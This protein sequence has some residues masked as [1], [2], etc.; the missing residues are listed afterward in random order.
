MPHGEEIVFEP[1]EEMGGEFVGHSFIEVKK[2]SLYGLPH[3]TEGQKL[4]PGIPRE[5][6]H[7][8]DGWD[9]LAS[10]RDTPRARRYEW[11]MVELRKDG[12][13]FGSPKT[14]HLRPRVETIELAQSSRAAYTRTPFNPRPRN[15]PRGTPRGGSSAGGNLLRELIVEQKQQYQVGLEREREHNRE[16]RDQERRHQEE[17][18]Q[19]ER[20]LNEVRLQRLEEKISEG[21][22]RKDEEPSPFDFK[23]V[24]GQAAVKAIER[25]EEG[26][27]N[28]LLGTLKESEESTGGFWGFLSEVTR[29]VIEAVREDPAGALQL[30][31]T[32]LPGLGAAVARPTPQPEATREQ[33]QPEPAAPITRQQLTDVQLL[34]G[35]TTAL[36]NGIVSDADPAPY[37]QEIRDILEERPH[38]CGSL[39]GMLQ[40]T[41]GELLSTLSATA[42]VSFDALGRKP[43]K[44]TRDLRVALQ[45]YGIGAEMPA[46]VNVST[47]GN[48]A[49]AGAGHG[50]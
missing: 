48:G 12:K 20:Q 46:P 38:L 34:T 49:A 5:F 13:V 23:S 27:A 29:D 7:T 36:A 2:H 30:A 1:D 10:I 15:P 8:V 35:L 18:H 33:K 41:D 16:L 6:I 42:R 44:W 26:I 22:S 50:D 28:N 14:V 32:V 3:Y 43:L 11:L 19:L 31:S 39:E 4:H 25:G 9:Y 37:A 24:L 40:Q 47:N 17:K 45:C 21:G